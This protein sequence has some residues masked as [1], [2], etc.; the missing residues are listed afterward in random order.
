MSIEDGL[1]R[2]GT[3]HGDLKQLYPRNQSELCKQELIKLNVKTD[4]EII[5]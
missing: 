4:T 1:Y 5:L 3:V 2:T